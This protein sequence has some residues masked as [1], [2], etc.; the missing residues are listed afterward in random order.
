MTFHGF[1]SHSA[2][3]TRGYIPS[4]SEALL[5]NTREIRMDHPFVRVEGSGMIAQPMW[6]SHKSEKSYDV[7]HIGGGVQWFWRIAYYLT[8]MGV[9]N[10]A[11]LEAKPS[12]SLWRLGAPTPRSF[13]Q[14]PHAL[15]AFAFYDLS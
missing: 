11:V 5:C 8:Q 2:E 4:P 10:I 6:K 9:R 12:T 7:V 15:K 13:I 1:R 14:L 3:L